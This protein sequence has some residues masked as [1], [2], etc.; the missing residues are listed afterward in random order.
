MEEL[1]LNVS[2]LR[3]KIPNLTVAARSAGLRPATVSNLCTGK[4]P[5]G[6]AEVRTLAALASLAGCTMDEL[7][8]RGNPPSMLET[9][10]KVLDLMAPLVK[11]GS[12]GLVARQN[13][14]Q[15]T[16]LSELFYRLNTLDYATVF[17]NPEAY[18]KG[19][20]E[21]LQEAD[22]VGTTSVEI[23]ERILQCAKSGEVIL[24]ADRA[25]V[26]SGEMFD[27]EEK[28]KSSGIRPITKILVDVSGN[29]VDEELPFGPLD[30]FLRFDPELTTRGLFPAV[31]PVASTSVMLEGA[32]LEPP[33]LSIQQET[34]KLMRR[35]R[36]LRPLV[37]YRGEEKLPDSERILFKRGQRLE[38]Y[39]S[40]PFFI[41]E[42]FTKKK[43]EWIPLRE[44]LQDVRTIL[45]GGADHVPVESIHFNGRLNVNPSC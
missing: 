22:A 40:Q 15:L 16:L 43:A 37:L 25:M 20:D 3:A 6:R 44:T 28:L 31:D 24:G 23:Y 39:L 13:I 33:H 14:G 8:I 30:T 26:L 9:G 12:I 34:R 41:A 36:D 27:L 19:I 4:I 29:A 42:P 11:G 1:H 21:L 10:I 32:Q 7:V 2:L 5:V 45:D 18:T 38:A 17:W 35:Y